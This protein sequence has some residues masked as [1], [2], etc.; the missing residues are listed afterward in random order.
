MRGDALLRV[1]GH[2]SVPGLC[3]T[4]TLTGEEEGYSGTRVGESEVWSKREC[5]KEREMERH[6]GST[7]RRGRE[8]ERTHPL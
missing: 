5:V 8:G 1:L 7:K 2:G 3:D 6:R 4:N